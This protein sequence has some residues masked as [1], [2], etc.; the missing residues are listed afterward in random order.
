MIDFFG[1]IKEVIIKIKTSTGIADILE[2][3]HNI[4]PNKQ[5]IENISVLIDGIEIYFDW[6]KSNE[7]KNNWIP[8]KVNE[9]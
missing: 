2:I 7:P 3:Q 4:N 9:P 5:I 8:K 1:N 6:K